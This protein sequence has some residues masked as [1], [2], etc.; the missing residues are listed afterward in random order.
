MIESIYKSVRIRFL[1]ADRGAGTHT[2]AMTRIHLLPETIRNPPRTLWESKSLRVIET[3]LRYDSVSSLLTSL[4]TNG[5]EVNSI[6]VGFHETEEP[7]WSFVPNPH[8]GSVDYVN[9]C[10]TLSLLG[11]LNI[12]SSPNGN[13][14]HFKQEMQMNVRGTYSSLLELTKDILGIEY[15][16]LRTK[17]VEITAPT[18]LRITDLVYHGSNVALKIRCREEIAQELKAW[19]MFSFPD[20][21]I[22]QHQ[23]R[24]RNRIPI[25]LGNGLVEISKSFNVPPN[26]AN[27]NVVRM[28]VSIGGIRGIALDAYSCA[29]WPVANIVRSTIDLLNPNKVGKHFQLQNFESRFS[30]MGSGHAAEVLEAVVAISLTACGF[31]VAWLG[32]FDLSCKDILAFV[33]GTNKVLVVECTVGS[34]DRKIGLMKTALLGLRNQSDWLDF[35]GIVVTSIY[36]DDVQRTSASRNGVGLLDVTDLKTLVQKAA[37]PPNTQELLN[38]L[39][40]T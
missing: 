40:I 15:G 6:P 23:P 18:Y 25:E 36:S 37:E 5:L 29:R 12:E 27:S 32:G 7:N 16:S 1:L 21:S 10:T 33:P 31:D 13:E 20:G 14:P 4:V 2:L 24:F 22:I 26:A 8:T 19:A 35:Y 17:Q 11:S 9:D 39:G 3:T 30:S 38:W 28:T 34:P